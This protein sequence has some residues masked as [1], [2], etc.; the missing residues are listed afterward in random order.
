MYSKKI[1]I[2]FWILPLLVYFIISS[3]ITVNADDDKSIH[4]RYRNTD[5]ETAT[6]VYIEYTGRTTAYLDDGYFY[7]QSN[8]KVKTSDIYYRTAGFTLSRI[9]SDVTNAE[10]TKDPYY[11]INNSRQTVNLYILDEGVRSEYY[12]TYNGTEYVTTQW[13]HSQEEVMQKIKGVSE[14][15]YQELVDKINNGEQAWIGVDCIMYAYKTDEA[16]DEVRYNKKIYTYANWED[17]LSIFTNSRKSLATHFDKFLELSGNKATVIDDKDE[18]PETPTV[19]DYYTFIKNRLLTPGT[20][21]DDGSQNPNFGN[22]NVAN[23]TPKTVTYNESD[24][25]NVGE[26]I[27]ADEVFNNHIEVDNWYGKFTIKQ[28]TTKTYTFNFNYSGYWYSSTTFYNEKED[29]YETVTQPHVTS[30]TITR[31]LS[32][33]Q[34]YEIMDIDLYQL[35]LNE[36]GT[37]SV[38]VSW[39]FDDD[40]DAKYTNTVT[41]PYSITYCGNSWTN[42]SDK[43]QAAVYYNLPTYTK[44][45][46]TVPAEYTGHVKVPVIDTSSIYKDSSSYSSAADVY[47]AAKAVVDERM[48]GKEILTTNDELNINNVNYLDQAGICND[49]TLVNNKSTIL[50]AAKQSIGYQIEKT[51]IDRTIAQQEVHIPVTQANDNYYTRLET[52][53]K[54]FIFL[55]GYKD[56]TVSDYEGYEL[57]IKYGYYDN[58]PIKVQTPVIAPISIDDSNST[59]QMGSREY[60]VLNLDGTYTVVFDWD[61]YFAV[62]YKGYDPPAGFTKYLTR[63]EVRFAF[64]V[65]MTDVSGVEKIYEVGEDG[66]TD[67]I[68]LDDDGSTTRFD[69]YIPSWAVEKDY[70]VGVEVKVY[71]NNYL[72]AGQDMENWKQNED[73]SLSDPDMKHFYVA[74]Y[75]L[76]IS[77]QGVMYGFTVTGINDKT[78]FGSDT[79][80]VYVTGVHQFTR[81]LQEKTVGTYNRFN[82]NTN[83]D[84]HKYIRSYFIGTE[85]ENGTTSV[86]YDKSLVDTLP[87]SYGKSNA[88]QTMGQLAFGHKIGFEVKTISNLDDTG[89]LD[90]N[91]SYRWVSD[92]G[93]E[94]NAN[95]ALYYDESPQSVLIPYSGTT[96]R[97][98]SSAVTIDDAYFDYTYMQNWLD[99]TAEYRGKTTFQILNEK[100][101]K[102][103]DSS[104]AYITSANM[105]YSA[106]ED[107]LY[108][109][110]KNE[111]DAVLRYGDELITLTTKEKKAFTTSMQTWYG[112]Y[113]IPK[114]TK[115]L[116]I[117][118]FRSTCIDNGTA[119]TA[120]SDY[121]VS[122]VEDL[123]LEQLMEVE[124]RDGISG[125]E[126]YWIKSGFLVLNFEITAYDGNSEWGTYYNDYDMWAAEAGTW[127]TTNHSRTVYAY[128]T[129]NGKTP[130]EVYSGDVAIIDLSDGAGYNSRYGAE[131][132]YI[133]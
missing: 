62:K 20:N 19:N 37:Y 53:Y 113:Q 63:K 29:R 17:M 13:K 8:D 59:Y 91:A 98:N 58:E 120:M 1:K 131:P 70:D 52:W 79:S 104:G 18:T 94:T 16:G 9:R 49:S 14:E 64:T 96:S 61:D 55:K 124:A 76:P 15:W 107:Q 44:D 88:H 32:A 80:G 125:E 3:Y 92:D 24:K 100:N 38:D 90:V 77:V 130:I 126:S 105:L 73:A 23:A 122:K 84:Y 5:D 43:L 10:N 95:I 67:W 102:G 50:E 83:S 47:N 60:D 35:S 86:E 75:S 65:Q 34:F 39:G 56:F 118:L 97:R 11:Y 4:T 54:S 101:I 132:L 99:I 110:E 2:L 46:Y 112:E 28:V 71:A 82:I 114:K 45:G 48:S 30:G 33:K 116:D 117:A 51:N 108:V 119:A 7:W 72:E 12:Y 74:T 42:G 6:N 133:D 68:V 121:G 87:F 115:V 129:N 27:P 78:T 111:G 123:T 40:V 103:Y 69:I 26:A 81:Y 109:N 106:D 36:D 21:A 41:V 57:A 85:D 66:Y 93:S 127:D 89:T 31:T 22:S 25:F 128:N